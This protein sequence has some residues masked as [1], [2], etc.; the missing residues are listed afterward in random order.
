MLCPALARKLFKQIFIK[1]AR[2]LWRGAQRPFDSLVVFAQAFEGK[3]FAVP[4][5]FICLF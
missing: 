3:A 1:I 2:S 4:G 5:F